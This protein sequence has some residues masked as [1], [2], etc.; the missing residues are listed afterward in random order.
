MTTRLDSPEYLASRV[1]LGL[2]TAVRL[3]ALIPI[4][5]GIAMFFITP[6]YSTE[7]LRNPI[8]WLLLVLGIALTAGGYAANE[9]AIRLSRKGKLPIGLA[10]VA[11][12]TV[13]LTFPAL[14]IVFIGPALIAFIQHPS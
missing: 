12:S 6:S 13:F 3:W 10:L 2:A 14:W 11:V 4:P 9:F 8:G 5:L 1:A 7:L